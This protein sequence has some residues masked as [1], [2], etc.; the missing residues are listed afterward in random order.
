VLGDPMGVGGAAYMSGGPY[1]NIGGLKS[2]L[3]R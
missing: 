3:A 1:Q 2:G